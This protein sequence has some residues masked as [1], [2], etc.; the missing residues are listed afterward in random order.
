MFALDR[1]TRR[2]LGTPGGVVNYIEDVPQASNAVIRQEHR[3][4]FGFAG[5]Q[6]DAVQASGGP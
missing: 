1:S 5:K 6:A 2:R 3:R 4:V